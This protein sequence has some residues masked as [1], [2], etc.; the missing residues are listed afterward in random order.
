VNVVI[1]SKIRAKCGTSKSKENG[2][3]WRHG[4]RRVWAGGPGFCNLVFSYKVFTIKM[5]LS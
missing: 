1:L 4:R 5:F 3:D 2:V